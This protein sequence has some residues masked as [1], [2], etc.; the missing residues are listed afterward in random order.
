MEFGQD[1]HVLR[2]I[3]VLVCSLLDPQCLLMLWKS[4]KER[5]SQPIPNGKSLVLPIFIIGEL[6]QLGLQC[7]LD[8]IC[9]AQ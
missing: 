3:G 1:S 9:N 7:I 5:F 2:V 6:V 4:I 8:V